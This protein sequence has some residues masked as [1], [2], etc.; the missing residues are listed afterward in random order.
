MRPLILLSSILAA[1]AMPHVFPAGQQKPGH[2]PV[3]THAF[4][5][6]LN[7]GMN[8]QVF[9]LFVVKLNGLHVLGT[10]PITREQFV[11]QAQGAV[12][13]KA[14]PEKE[15]LFR[16]YK[17]KP[18]MHPDS[19]RYYLDCP[20]FDDLWKLRFRE[21]PFAI[22]DGYNPGTG[23]AG[24]K[25][26][27]TDRQLFMLAEYGIMRLSDMIHGENVFRLLRDAGDSTWVNGYRIGS[28]P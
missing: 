8:N 24:Q 4:G 12:E 3:I 7:T 16:K 17:V 26:S 14:N 20:V 15:N 25:S 28:A 18:C 10:E 1:L 27:P 19:T 21:Y 13:S 23:W 11:L 5:L 2:S 6:S 22:L 9:T